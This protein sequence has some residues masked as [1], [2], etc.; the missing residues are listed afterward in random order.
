[1]KL[2]A[3]LFALAFALTTF[4]CASTDD[5]ASSDQDII[6]APHE[7]PCGG[8]AQLA[9]AEDEVCTYASEARCGFGDQT[10]VCR[11][12]PEFCPAVV[13]PVC[14]CEGVTYNNLCE[15]SRAGTSVAHGGVCQPLDPPPPPH[16]K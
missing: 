6:A 16:G 11:K 15:A 12:R 13:N 9:C 8:V 14:G 1:M 7:R 2:A 10:G 4:A 3:P 5:T